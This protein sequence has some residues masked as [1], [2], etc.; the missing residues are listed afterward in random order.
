MNRLYNNESHQLVKG[1]DMEALVFGV[2]VIGIV[3]HYFG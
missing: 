2:I 3:L 1:V